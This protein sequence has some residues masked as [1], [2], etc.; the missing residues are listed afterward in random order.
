MIGKLGQ[1]KCYIIAEAGVNH[2]ISQEEMQRIGCQNSLEVTYKLVD[3]AVDCGADAIKFQS[4][5]ADKLQFKGTQKLNIKK[6]QPLKIIM[7]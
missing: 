6:Q 1:N 7:S 5:K 4:F 2:I 3:T